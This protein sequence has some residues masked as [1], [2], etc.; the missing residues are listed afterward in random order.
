MRNR[1]KSTEVIYTS[2][3]EYIGK[4]PQRKLQFKENKQKLGSTCNFS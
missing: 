4:G 2:G 3:K 1:F